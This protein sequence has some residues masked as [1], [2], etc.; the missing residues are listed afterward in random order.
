MKLAPLLLAFSLVIGLAGFANSFTSSLDKTS[1]SVSESDDSYQ[2]AA[3]YDPAKTDKVRAALDDHLKQRND[4]SF[5]NTDLDATMTLSNNTIFYIKSSPG[6]LLIKL[7]KKRN[8]DQA[9]ARFKKLSQDL[10][11]LLTDKS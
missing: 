11:E 10:R 3:T 7:D 6:Q 8:S 2:I 1:F 4:G 9:L 5:K